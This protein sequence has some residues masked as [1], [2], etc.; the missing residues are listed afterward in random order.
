MSTRIILIRHGETDWNKERRYLSSTDIDINDTGKE[1]I[2]SAVEHIVN[3]KV[4]KVY[5][6]DRK[7]ALTSVG[8]LFN[9]IILE[10]TKDLR[11]MDFG[12]FEGL[13]HEEIKEKFSDIYE[14]WIEDP[15]KTIIPGGEAF[16]VF[17]SRVMNKLKAITRNDLGCTV[18]IV[19]H[20][21]VIRLILSNI[22]EAEKFWDIKMVRPAS[23][24][25]IEADKE[26]LFTVKK[27]EP[28]GDIW[29]RK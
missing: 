11:E 20:G 10:K 21:G 17:E 13:R 1:Q 28:E 16:G 23:V 25:I 3:E 14:A 26:L 4:T 5:A 22:L 9:N 29:P 18:A 19:T 6:S 12:V 24:T 7:R 27:Y 8:L 15:R 2:L